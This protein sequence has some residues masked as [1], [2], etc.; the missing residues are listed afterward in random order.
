[1]LES[2][3]IKVLQERLAKN[4]WKQNKDDLDVWSK[5][6]NRYWGLSFNF[7]NL[8]IYLFCL[9]NT[10]E[11]SQNKYTEKALKEIQALGIYKDEKTNTL[12]W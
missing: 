5:K 1:M 6:L 3:K 7:K 11:K 10:T 9:T 12:N 8:D 2:E 4:K